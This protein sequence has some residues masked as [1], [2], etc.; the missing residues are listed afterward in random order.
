MT[1]KEAAAALGVKDGLVYKLCAYGRL[2]H[3][4]L[5][6]GKGVIQI[7][8]EAVAEYRRACEIAPVPLDPA[9][10]GAAPLPRR[11]RYAVPDYVPDKPR[12]AR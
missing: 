4:R 7:D 11:A 9:R 3:R 10:P 8:P 2:R 12:K 6:F 5:G 1:V